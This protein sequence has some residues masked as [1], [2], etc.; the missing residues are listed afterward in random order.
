MTDETE[1]GKTKSEEMIHRDGHST[2]DR[3]TDLLT[4]GRT[5][6]HTHR[7]TDKQN[8]KNERKKERW[9]AKN[10][11]RKN[12]YMLY[13]LRQNVWTFTNKVEEKK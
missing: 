10:E 12:L 2:K 6:R 4:G 9:A 8:E 11:D 7:T 13:R 3:Q 1:R 5:D